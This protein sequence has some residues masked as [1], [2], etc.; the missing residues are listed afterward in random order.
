MQNIFLKTRRQKGYE[1]WKKEVN[2]KILSL[3]TSSKIC[4]AAILE[5]DEIIKEVIT[6]NKIT[7]SVTLMPMIDNL[8]KN[9]NY[10]LADMDLIV[11]DVGP[12][13]FTGIRVG[14]ATTKAF[15]DALSINAIG[16]SSLEAL[17][18]NV[19]QEG[20]ICSIIDAKH[21]NVYVGIFENINGKHILK[22]DLDIKNIDEL[23]EELKDKYYI[24]QN[25]IFVGDGIDVYK[26]KILNALSKVKISSD[27]M[28]SAINI[29]R[30]GMD[31][32]V[33]NKYNEVLP[34]YLRKT[35]AELD[36]DIKENIK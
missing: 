19:K 16:I 20:I 17:A 36:K 28:I 30:A 10:K 32:L 5:D 23:I 3:T 31:H 33:D 24:E 15:S 29:A 27:N 14:A 4:S 35:Q 12:G 21:D 2:L 34:L 25:I 8:F 11:C 13:S 18:Y 6:N 26:E 1:Q 22:E 9:V 7:H